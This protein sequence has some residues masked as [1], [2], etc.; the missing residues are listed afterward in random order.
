MFEA[1]SGEGVARVAVTETSEALAG[2]LRFC[3]DGSD[4]DLD[5]V[6][7]IPW[8]AIKAL[9]KYDVRR[10]ALAWSLDAADDGLGG[11][12][13]IQSRQ[14]RGRTQVSLRRHHQAGLRAYF[15]VRRRL[16]AQDEG[17][18]KPATLVGLYMLAYCYDLGSVDDAVTRIIQAGV[19]SSVLWEH[20][21][22]MRSHGF[23]D[24]GK[25]VSASLLPPR[26]P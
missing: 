20:M 14:P 25:L 7:N 6:D 15:E 1:V 13:G 21:T 9:D 18:S 17:P 23:T 8:G 3:R 19:S 26:I 12:D 22:F 16:D 5:D 11:T 24:H 2:V 4:L 10:P